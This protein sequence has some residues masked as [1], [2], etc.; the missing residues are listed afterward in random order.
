MAKFTSV[1]LPAAVLAAASAWATSSQA[2]DVR[3]SSWAPPKHLINSVVWPT[4]LSCLAKESGGSI[5]GKIVYKLAPP[6]RQFDVV[7]KGLADASWIFHGYNAGK[8]LATQAVEIPLLGASAE[9]GS[10][11][12]WRTHV[13][14]LSK[15]NEHKGVMVMSLTTHGPG[16]IQTKTPINSLADLKG[17]K[18]RL[19][20][21]VASQVGR[22]VGAISVKVPAPKVYEV[23]S[24][25]VAD[26]IF[27]PMETQKSF[28]LHEVAKNVVAMPGGLYY[29]SFAFIF[30]PRK[31]RR[32]NRKEKAAF[33]RCSG[34]TLARVAG[35]AWDAADRDG[36]KTASQ[37]HGNVKQAS[38]AMQ[39]EFKP[40]AARIEANWIKA[41]AKRGIN[42]A[43]ALR[44][45]RAQAKKV[46]ASK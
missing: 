28:R 43:A 42:G 31:Y 8:Y 29:G 34:E 12:Y 35:K 32:F 5:K 15:A 45:L 17:R 4:W 36:W 14:Y 24:S 41:V 23:L 44:Y 25:G 1:A 11:A 6:P 19:P 21:G 39:K 46:D 30:N 40:I 38:A 3:V 7:R 10:V 2:I 27:M 37:S 33:R 13:R 18:I 16:V 20:G 22:A 26:G 9:A